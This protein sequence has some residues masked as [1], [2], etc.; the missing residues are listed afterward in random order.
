[1]AHA[2]FDKLMSRLRRNRQVFKKINI[3][4]KWGETLNLAAA[5]IEAIRPLYMRY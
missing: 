2:E 5:V 3:A 4:K 1:M